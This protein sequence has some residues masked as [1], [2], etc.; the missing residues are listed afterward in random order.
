LTALQALRDRGGVRPGH[1]VLVNGASG[2]VGTYAVQL[3]K[4][5]GAEVTGVCSTRNVELVK[6]LGADRVIDYT[7][8]DFLREAV[9]YDL[10]VDNVGNRPL[11]ALRDVVAPGGAIVVVGGRDDEPWLGPAK[12]MLA[13]MA[14]APFVDARLEAF[15]SRLNRTDLEY[16]AGLMAAGRLRST[17]DRRFPLEQAADA[18]RYLETGR[19]RGKVI[20]AVA[21]AATP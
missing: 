11:L 13:A 6:S 2:G 4:V 21:S 7:R 5:F 20:V 16:L 15:V 3:A 18:L 1:R 14:L 12:R 17:I 19:A 9:R 8:E 10:I